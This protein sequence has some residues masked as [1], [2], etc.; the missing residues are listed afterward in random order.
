[1]AAL[2]RITK[3]FFIQGQTQIVNFKNFINY[4]FTQKVLR[5]FTPANRKCVILA[6][7]GEQTLNDKKL[8]HLEIFISN[9]HLNVYRLLL[10]TKF[11]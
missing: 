10:C 4:Q 6:V 3:L 1:M 2:K 9:C 5:N 7:K 8:L 11:P